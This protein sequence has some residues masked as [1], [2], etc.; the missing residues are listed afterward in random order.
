MRHVFSG[1][2]SF[3]ILLGVSSLSVPALAAAAE[4]DV[5]THRLL[6]T[7][8]ALAAAANLYEAEG[9]ALSAP[10]QLER[11]F[12][13]DGLPP[14]WPESVR[15]EVRSGAWWVGVSVG[16]YS[17]ARKFLRA[18]APA[19]G[20]FDA[21]EGSPWMGASFVWLE[22]V[23]FG[24]GRKAEPFG[25]KIAEGHGEAKD[26][27]FFNAPGT[28]EYWWSP[29]RFTAPARTLALKRWGRTVDVPELTI[30]RAQDEEKESFR[31]SPV[32]LPEEFGVSAD[33]ELGP[34]VE[35]GD[36]IFNPIP[37]TRNN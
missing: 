23:R 26:A 17:T 34:S 36:V 32:G 24:A 3:L 14:D 11:Y 19:L 10:A 28:E 35:M 13:R 1:V 16:N 37:R 15:T 20:V 4:P 18:N 12:Q 22:A 2:L 8:Y 31:A 21:P 33:Q 27:L 25:V 6:G 29:L 9:G 7:L 5:E 30:P